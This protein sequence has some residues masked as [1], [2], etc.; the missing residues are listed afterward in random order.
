MDSLFYQNHMNLFKD[1][2][3]CPDATLKT[4]EC[5]NVLS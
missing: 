2:Q 1:S 4:N 3:G 5:E